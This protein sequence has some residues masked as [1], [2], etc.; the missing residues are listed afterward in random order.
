MSPLKN[1]MLLL[2]SFTDVP[3]ENIYKEQKFIFLLRYCN[4]NLLNYN[5]HNLTN[6]F[7]DALASNSS[8][9]SLIDNIFSNIYPNII[10]S[11]LT[12]TISDQLS[13]LAII[14]NI[15]GNTTSKHKKSNIYER[16]WCKFDLENFIDYF[17]ID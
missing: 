16:D 8:I 14:P 7:L 9:P 5:E 13:Q 10:S 1:Q 11:N 17:S 12:A 6:E 3:L 15:S 4:V 2:E